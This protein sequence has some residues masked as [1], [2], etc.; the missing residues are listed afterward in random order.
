MT[1]DELLKLPQNAQE[2]WL[3]EQVTSFYDLVMDGDHRG[4]KIN[5]DESEIQHLLDSPEQEEI[6][7]FAKEFCPE[8]SSQRADELNSGA[9]VTTQEKDHL[10]RGM[11]QSHLEAGTYG[12]VWTVCPVKCSNTEVFATFK[13]FYVGPIAE[14]FFDRFYRT[15]LQAINSIETLSDE[16]YLF[17]I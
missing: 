17:P 15:K 9:T 13:S 6:G 11:A 10:I 12:W 5:C 7:N 2:R 3:K 14:E 1:P 16:E 4:L 8:I